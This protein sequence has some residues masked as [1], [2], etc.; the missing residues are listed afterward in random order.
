MSDAS[1]TWEDNIPCGGEEYNVVQIKRSKR[2]R[3]FQCTIFE[4]LNK[5]TKVQLLLILKIDWCFCLMIKSY[6]QKCTL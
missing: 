3:C 2:V 6:Y 5:G 4:I 1:K